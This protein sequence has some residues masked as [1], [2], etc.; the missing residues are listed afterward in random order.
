MKTTRHGDRSMMLRLVLVGVVAALGVSVPSQPSCEHWYESAQAWT[1][2]L[3]AEWDTWEPKDEGVPRLVG[4]QNSIGCEEC[5]LA[6]MRLAAN[7]S[8]ASK[9]TEKL[10]GLGVAGPAAGV[11]E[12]LSPAADK[13][14]PGVAGDLG[15]WGELYRITGEPA[16]IAAETDIALT[17]DLELP[18]SDCSFICGFGAPTELHAPKCSSKPAAETPSQAAELVESE[19]SAGI[20][21]SCLDEE[22]G[23]EAEVAEVVVAARQAPVFDE[24]PSD[25]FASPRVTVT[26]NAQP[27][28][29]KPAIDAPVAVVVANLERPVASSVLA[30]LPA[31]VFVPAPQSFDHK[32]L[33]P[34]P[35]LAGAQPPAPRLGDAVELTRRAMSAWASLLI[36]PALVDGSRR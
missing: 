18:D 34:E 11:S 32:P 22:C 17:E 23:I 36:G 27:V 16:A 9:G 29:L 15:I 13:S 1:T 28:P 10:E 7:A 12:P 21:M 5:R 24:L 14:E 33:S 26:T 8:D 31:D 19:D 25:V 30:E 35:P 3:L 4:T 20:V 2:S 6:R